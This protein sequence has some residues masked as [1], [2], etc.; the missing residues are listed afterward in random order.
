MDKQAI[1]DDILSQYLSQILRRQAE[2]HKDDEGEQLVMFGY[3][4][5]T[6]PI[7]LPITLNAAADRIDSLER[8]LSKLTYVDNIICEAARRR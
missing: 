5:N 6:I 8:K 2:R 7:N 4:V 1:I 3:E